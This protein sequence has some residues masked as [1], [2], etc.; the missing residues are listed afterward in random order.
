MNLAVGFFDGVHAG[1]QRILDGADS[2][3]TFINHP[4]TVLDP[5]NAPP[6]LMDLDERIR[7][8]ET[9]GLHGSVPR[10][11]FAVEFT[12]DLAQCPPLRFAELLRSEHPSLSRIHCGA[13]WRFGARGAGT[14]ETLR[15]MG[16]DV[17]VVPYATYR[18]E[19]ISSTRIRE[20]LMNGCVED[21]NAMLGR[22]FSVTGRVFRGKGVAHGLGVATVNVAVSAPLRLGVYAVGT[23]LG[24]GVANYGVA[25]TMGADAWTAP[26]L[27][28]HLLDTGRTAEFSV[29]QVLR[30]EF[31]SF[32]RPEMKFASVSALKCQMAE[33]V[34][35]V[36]RIFRQGKPD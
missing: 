10:K 5:D 8:L 20:T 28:I 12:R 11:V 18:G 25:P 15:G 27:E 4:D 35:A 1:H 32:I 36:R 34:A 19:R 13:N 21:A 23:S 29:P 17:K 26:V 2:V 24:Y 14:P 33:D 31:H 3:F 22:R 30:T 7:C 9:A 16:F 6:L